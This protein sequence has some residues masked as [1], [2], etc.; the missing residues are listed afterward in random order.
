MQLTDS[1]TLPVRAD[2]LWEVLTDVELIAPCVPGF[3]LAESDHPDYRGAMRV[4]V[5]AVS[6]SYDATIT[7]AERDD[8][9]R[10]AVLKVAG[11]ERRGAGTVNAT[12]TATLSE[13]G[14]STTAE[15]VTDVQLT[16]RVAQ[17]GRGIITDV[18]SRITKQFVANL[19]QQV[20]SGAPAT[21]APEPAAEPAAAQPADPVVEQRPPAAPLDLGAAAAMPV[22][23]R[24]IPA[25]LLLALLAL[26]VRARA[27]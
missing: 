5:G 22:L 13:A 24:A 15:M 20:L 12:V 7:F 1:F 25:V 8:A 16:G 2:R 26:L 4:K 18:S 9:A 23:K 6:V 10:R 14:D 21:A 19:D 3:E 17:F 11:R 27:R